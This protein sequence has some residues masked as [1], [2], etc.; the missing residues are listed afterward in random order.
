LGGAGLGVDAIEAFG[1][2]AF[3]DEAGFGA[4]W[5]SSDM[6]DQLVLSLTLSR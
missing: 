5:D 3:G 2:A 6:S 4:E 1:H